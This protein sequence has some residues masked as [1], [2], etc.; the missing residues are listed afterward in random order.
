ML[1][2]VT[3]ASLLILITAIADSSL[4]SAQIEEGRPVVIL[5]TPDIVYAGSIDDDSPQYETKTIEGLFS[6]ENEGI[7]E[8][9]YA[10]EILLHGIF[11]N[12]LRIAP[13]QQM[14]ILALPSGNTRQTWVNI[15]SIFFD[16]FEIPSLYIHEANTWEDA[17]IPDLTPGNKLFWIINEINE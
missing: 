8:K 12:G 7:I 3:F 17:I 11:Y 16:T 13:E 10:F 15:V 9:I 14:I 6:H 1:N 2:K 4:V 5:I